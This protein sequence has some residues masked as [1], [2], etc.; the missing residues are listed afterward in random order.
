MLDEAPTGL[1]SPQEKALAAAQRQADSKRAPVGVGAL[2]TETDSVT[3][4][5]GGTVTWKTSVMPERTR[6]KGAWV[7]VDSTLKKNSNGSYGPSAATGSLTFSGGGSGPL[8]TMKSGKSQLALSWPTPLPPPT[9]SGSEIT[10]AV[11][12]DVDLKLKANTVGGFTQVLVV[13][14]AAAAANPQLASLK[15]AMHASGLNVS[16]DGHDNVEAKA[17]NGQVV[18]SAPQSQMWESPE[19]GAKS[20]S[21]A[22]TS[23]TTPPASPGEGV[24]SAPVATDV[25]GSTLTLTPDKALLTGSATHYPVYIDPSWNPHTLPGSR[26]HFV[27]VQQGCPTAKNWDSTRYGDPGV[28]MNSWSG[29]IGLERSYFQLGIPSAVWGTHIVDAVVNTM[30]TGSSSCSLSASANLY[31]ANSFGSGTTWNNRPGLVSKLGTQSFGPACSSYQSKGYGVT[32]TIAK[33]AAGKSASW[34]FALL[35][36]NESDGALFRR[37]A[38][39]PSLSITYNHVPNTPSALAAVVNTASYGCD[40]VAPYPVIGKTI[41]TTPPALIS[42]VSDGDKDALS[43]TYTYWVDGTTAKKTITSANV[44]SGEKPKV[45]LPATFISTL[46]D[47]STVDWQVSTTDGKDTRANSAVCHFTVDQ[48]APEKPVIVSVGGLFPENAPE[49]DPIPGA[50]AG[51]GAVFKASVAPGSTNNTAAKF[52]FGLDVQPPTSNPPATQV[53]AAVNNSASYTIA[54]PSPGTHTLW[55]YALDSAGNASAMASYL[56]VAKGHDSHTYASLKDA[57][58]NTAVSADGSPGSA[59]L[60]GNGYSLS[61]QD[62]QAAG[63]QSGGKVRIN[64]AEFTLPSFGSGTPDNVLASNQTIKMNG[65]SGKSLVFL[66]TGSFANTGYDR[67]AQDLSSPVIPDGTPS[68]AASC[69]LSNGVP[70]D[71]HPATGEISYSD[72]T[73]PSPY[74]LSTP[75]WTPGSS[76]LAVV[77]LPHANTMSGQRATPV[78]IYA[79]SVPLKPGAKID[80]VTLPD[81]SNRAA[82]G[83]PGL[84]IFGMAVRDTESAPG[85]ASWAGAWTAPTEASYNYNANSA[86]YKDQTFRTVVHSDSS[87]S[88][89]RFR[90]SNARGYVPLVIDHATFALNVPGPS[91]SADGPVADLTFD[92]GKH[93][94]TIPVGAE[95]Y[96]DPFA[97]E[98]PAGKNVM[99]SFHLA[100]QV[101]YLPQHSWTSNYSTVYVTPAGS[102]D[103]TADS[104]D[105]AFKAAG[106]TWGRF[107]HILTGVDL[108]TT[109]GHPVTVVIGDGL[110]DQGASGATPQSGLARLAEWLSTAN[111]RVLNAGIHNNRLAVDQTGAGAAVLTRLDRDVLSVAGVKTVVINEGLQDTLAAVDDGDLQDSYTILRDQL[112]AWGIKTVFTTLTPCTGYAPCTTAV[113]ANRVETNAWIS[114]QRTFTTPYVDYVDVASA[115]SVPDPASDPEAPTMRLGNGAAPADYDAGDHLNFTRDGYMA[116]AHAFDPSQLLPDAMPST[117]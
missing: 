53:V 96:T 11:L 31:S 27:E 88:G 6:Q 20:A 43:A 60:D 50:P 79:I 13:K 102:G 15:L 21:R 29:C 38:A 56:L 41:A 67:E 90:L 70:T 78:K 92:G 61:L 25:S 99:L 2:T 1:T 73:A 40:T 94:I 62:L 112:S 113:D 5:P 9:T 12:P 116:L 106:V 85:G 32:S 75:D 63:W 87:G 103:H 108:L 52:V 74:Y 16:D 55:V 24:K 39:N 58:N 80:S 95:I 89:V 93:A 45:S 64:G 22:L 107:A 68:V 54:P 66:A 19:P 81:I 8:V 10:Y 77:T 117:E 46:K 35:N 30:S 110:T 51:T 14:T 47:G 33:V 100:N 37:F 28:G 84:H 44:S 82:N 48:R 101:T 114:G 34:T 97:V 59:D 26:Q 83:N 86:D 115:V 69:T 36:T 57:F 98:V 109:E 49:A 76:P 91:P 23:D 111:T 105:T 4:N 65:E 42:T 17:P 7:P 72:S 3:A 104:G 71:C 18:F